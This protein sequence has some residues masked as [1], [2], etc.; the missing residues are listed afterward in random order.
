MRSLRR[1]MS[2]LNNRLQQSTKSLRCSTTSLFNT[3]CRP[4][5]KFF[6]NGREVDSL[7]GASVGALEAKIELHYVV[8][9]ATAAS[10]GSSSSASGYPDITSN[11]D[12]KN[13]NLP[14]SKLT[15]DGM[16]ESTGYASCTKCH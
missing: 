7:Q 1:S 3:D 9:H 15:L 16:L 8:V 14:D 11:I 4:T 2:M 10:R 13:V 12:I 5:F 6:K